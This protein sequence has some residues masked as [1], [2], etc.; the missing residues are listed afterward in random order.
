MGKITVLSPNP[1]GQKHGNCTKTGYQ[2]C[3]VPVENIDVEHPYTLYPLHHF[4]N[5]STN[6]QIVGQ[7]YPLFVKWVSSFKETYNV[8]QKLCIKIP[9]G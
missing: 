1:G 8:D 3:I 2:L 9:S 4:R 7:I 6:I 5:T